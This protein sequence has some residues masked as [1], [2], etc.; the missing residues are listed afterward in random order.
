MKPWTISIKDIVC[1]CHLHQRTC[2]LPR[3]STLTSFQPK[4]NVLDKRA[5]NYAFLVQLD[6]PIIPSHSMTCFE[7]CLSPFNSSL[8]K[9]S[10][11]RYK[12]VLRSTIISK[13]TEF[14]R[15]LAKIHHMHKRGTMLGMTSLIVVLI[16]SHWS[17]YT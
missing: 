3:S 13:T 5:P 11:K 17:I 16:L 15:Y 7:F 9:L 6:Q 12:R 1:S 4:R 2:A 14:L 10:C 8:V